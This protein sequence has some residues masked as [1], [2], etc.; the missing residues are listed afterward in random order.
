[1]ETFI[2]FVINVYNV[3][4]AKISKFI[5]P[6]SILGKCSVGLIIIFFLLFGT[7]QL[8]IFSGQRGGDTFFSNL[9]LAIPALLSGILGI[10]AFFIGLISIIK[11][12]ERSF[13]VFLSI[14]IGFLVLV[15][16]AGEI[17]FP[18]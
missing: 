6:K 12:K 18:H 4:K 16:C 5:L 3:N 1:M 8:L 2:K 17:L 15:F 10:S 11:N 9:I 14:T 7:L 13:L